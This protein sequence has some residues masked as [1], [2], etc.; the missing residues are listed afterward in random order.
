[1]RVCVCVW[2]GVHVCVCVCVCVCVLGMHVLCKFG[3]SSLIDFS[4]P[5]QLLHRLLIRQVVYLFQKAQN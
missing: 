5:T 2:G 1:M 3:Q 4:T